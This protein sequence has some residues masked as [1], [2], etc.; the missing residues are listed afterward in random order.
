[1][2][3]RWNSHDV[4]ISITASSALLPR[5]GAPA[6]CAACPLNL[7]IAEMSAL[8]P[9]WPYNTARLLPT[10]VKSVTSTSLNTPARTNQALPDMSSSATPSQ[11]LIVPGMWSR[12][13]IFFTASAAAM[14][15]GSPELCPSPCPGAPS[16]SGSCQPTPGLLLACGVSS[17]SE[18]REITGFPEPHLAA[19]PAGLP[20]TVRS[21]FQPFCSRIPVR[22]FTVLNSLNPGPPH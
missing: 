5:H 1:M 7:K 2:C 19:N 8:E 13:M 3:S 12:S 22:D 6:A 15:S 21:T 16:T 18:P 11:T 9:D 20:A 10:C 17:M 4:P 14:L